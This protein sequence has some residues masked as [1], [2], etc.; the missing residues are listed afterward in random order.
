MLNFL[1]DVKHRLTKFRAKLRR[2]SSA[3]LEQALTTAIQVPSSKRS[4]AGPEVLF[5]HSSL[6][7]C[8]YLEPGA[9]G[10]IDALRGH[11]DTLCL[12]THTYCYTQDGNTPTYDPTSTLSLIGSVTNTF[13]KMPDV[14]RSI[15]PTHSLAAT[16]P[17]A[18]FLCKDH[19][20]CE[21][22]CGPDT[23]YAR[24]VELDAS[25]LMF[26]ATMNTYTL[27][28]LRRTRCRVLVP[29]F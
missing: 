2:I 29:L 11:C 8:G 17:K 9:E 6:S 3:Q 24:M 12:P 5:V 28:P 16:G 10:L 25:V 7:R 23:P 4:D 19:V 14:L 20:D 15:H 21:T 27:F 1:Y 13:W 26:G 18:E 22:A